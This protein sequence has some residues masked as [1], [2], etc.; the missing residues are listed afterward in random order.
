MHREHGE[1]AKPAT[2]R[3]F[4]FGLA[5]T[6]SGLRVTTQHRCPCRTLGDRAVLTPD[7]VRSLSSATPDVDH[8]VTNA[9]EITP[10]SRVA[11]ADYQALE[12]SLLARLRSGEDALAVL[13]AESFPTIDA[14]TWP[15]VGHLFR[16]SLDGTIGGDALATFG[17]EILRMHGYTASSMRP[18]SWTSAF[19]RAAVRVTAADVPEL[20]LNDF[21]ADN[22]WGL[23]WHEHP[24]A[25]TRHELATRVA[26]ARSLAA[27]FGAD[28]SAG[29]R[30][31]AEAIMVVELAGESSLWR[32]L[33]HQ[34]IVS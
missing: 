24:F 16:S 15:D 27:R 1:E 11:F 25:T 22:I 8:E 21:V 10:G 19:D 18:R 5:R 6:P 9:I 29:A 34:L 13:G 33:M 7:S 14:L 30:D 12:A 23:A 26:I 3:E 31:M 28:G 4:P 20:M 2:C 17:D 32:R